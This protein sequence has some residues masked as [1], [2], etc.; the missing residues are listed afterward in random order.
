[1]RYHACLSN[2]LLALAWRCRNHA[3]SI[4]VRTTCLES[5]QKNSHWV[6]NPRNEEFASQKKLFPAHPFTKQ[7]A[8]RTEAK[9]IAKKIRSKNSSEIEMTHFHNKNPASYVKK[10]ANSGDLKVKVFMAIATPP[11][12]QQ[13]D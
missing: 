10:S 1:M 12:L 4:R 9:K 3:W 13:S 2:C 8:R 5:V 6:S 11:D 7:P